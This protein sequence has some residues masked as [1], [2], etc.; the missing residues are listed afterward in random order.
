[1]TFN[2]KLFDLSLKMTFKLENRLY[3][4][5]L[6]AF[7]MDNYLKKVHIFRLVL[8]FRSIYFYHISK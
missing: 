6:F 2:I 5:I 4:E 8:N 3:Y 1:M 7:Y